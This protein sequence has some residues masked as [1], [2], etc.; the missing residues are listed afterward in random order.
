MI[1]NGYVYAKIKKAWYGL[2]Q[3]GK[4]A[5]DD[6]VLHLASFGYHK[7]PFTEGLFKHET[8]DIAFTLVVD[9]F[10]IKY[11]SKADADH[12]IAC[13]R[14]KYPFKVDWDAKQY[15]GIDL[16]FEY[17]TG[18]RHVILSMKGYVKQALT[19]FKHI[20]PTQHYYG[21]SKVEDPIYGRKVQYAKTDTSGTLGPK[22]IKRIQQVTGKF[23][24]YG[25]VIDDTIMHAM[26]HIASSKKSKDTLEATEYFL[27]YMASNPDGQLIYRESDMILQADSD[28][29]YLV[30][31][32]ARSRAGGFIYLS[33]KDQQLFNGPIMVI[34]KIIK[35]V[36][37][38]AAEAEAAALYMIA[39]EIVPLR[40][41]LI[42]LGHPQPPHP[43]QNR[44]HDSQ[45]HHERNN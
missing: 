2:K 7:V 16:E 19:E 33:N 34:A 40:Q 6:L 28:A 23:L 38:S 45:R 8:K 35:N 11:T 30:A 26:N 1:H 9:D 24:Y 14:A 12:L 21:P 20:H 37:A 44:Q 36:M 15:I 10:A 22:D 5:H 13:M 25:R 3:S 32:E 31:E 4:I 27:N 29:A 17:T 43:P 42:E 41:C 18:N 39:Q